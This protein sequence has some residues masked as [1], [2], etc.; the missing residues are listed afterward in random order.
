MRDGGGVI[1]F[2]VILIA[3][4]LFTEKE[5]QNSNKEFSTIVI[6]FLKEKNFYDKNKDYDK[7]LSLIYI[8]AI[9]FKLDP[10]LVFSICFVESSLYEKK[11]GKNSNGTIDVG[12]M[13]INS[14]HNIPK[15]VLFNSESNIVVGCKIL[16]EKIRK[17]NIYKAIKYY[18]GDGGKADKYSQRV[19]DLYYS[20]KLKEIE[21]ARQ[22]RNG[23]AM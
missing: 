1:V 23:N 2:L 17:H 8:N 22:K 21:Y 11:V 9:K 13:Q 12:L 15:E 10:Y 20:L 14:V 4:A 16:S 6:S 3:I 18:N 7:I 5:K 19:L